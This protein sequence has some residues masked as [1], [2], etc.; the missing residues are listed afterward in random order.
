MEKT[1]ESLLL[2]LVYI[3]ITDIGSLTLVVTLLK[4]ATPQSL[5]YGPLFFD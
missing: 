2:F 1:L 5:G 3:I 4:M